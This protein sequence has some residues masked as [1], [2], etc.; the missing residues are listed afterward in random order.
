MITKSSVPKI[1]MY[2]NEKDP[3]PALLCSA[4]L[5]SLSY[6]MC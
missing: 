5:G 6:F 1:Q 2:H 4:K 3:P